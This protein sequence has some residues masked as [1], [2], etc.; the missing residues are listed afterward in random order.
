MQN[1][2]FFF[3]LDVVVLLIMPQVADMK[4][5]SEKRADKVGFG[6]LLDDDIRDA[7]ID[8]EMMSMPDYLAPGRKTASANFYALHEEHLVNRLMSKWNTAKDESQRMRE[9]ARRIIRKIAVE[10]LAKDW[11]RSDIDAEVRSYMVSKILPTVVLGLEKLLMEVEKRELVE[12]KEPDDNF[13]PLNFLAQY[14]MRNN[15]KYGNF[16]EASSYLRGLR[17]VSEELKIQL[18]SG[19]SN[20]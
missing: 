8:E 17:N 15:P 9:Q 11:L 5:A 16:P 7:R 1:E 14:L 2:N 18:L 12:T 3:C 13:N 6:R 20:Q 4:M 10:E 19:S